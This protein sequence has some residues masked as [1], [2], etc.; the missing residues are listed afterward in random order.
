MDKKSKKWLYIAILL[1]SCSVF[2]SQIVLSNI[3]GFIFEKDYRFLSAS[4]ALLGLGA[5]GIF[6]SVFFKKIKANFPKSLSLTGFSYMATIVLPYLFLREI[7]LYGHNTVYIIILTCLAGFLNFFF[8]GLIISLIFAGTNNSIFKLSFFDLIG[9]TIGS[10]SIFFLADSLGIFSA[11][12]FLFAIGVGVFL[13][14]WIANYSFRFNKKTIVILA[15]LVAIILII[16]KVSFNTKCPSQFPRFIK[17]QSNSLT[18][19]CLYELERT[20]DYYEFGIS[21]REPLLTTN[22]LTNNLEN[23]KE[24]LDGFR[25]VIFKIANYKKVLVVG[26]GAGIDVSRALL[27]GSEEITAVEINKLMID[28]TNSFPQNLGQSPYQDKRVKTIVSDARVYMLQNKEKYDLLLLANARGFGRPGIQFLI[29]ENL[30][31]L[32]ALSEY[33]DKL[34][35][36]GTLAITNWSWLTER[37]LK[38]LAFLAV[39]KGLNPEKDL[40]TLSSFSNTE[41]TELMET[42]I[43]KKDGISIA[44]KGKI[45]SLADQFQ[46]TYQDNPVKKLQLADIKITTDDKPFPP[47]PYSTATNVRSN[48]KYVVFVNSTI[49][50]FKSFVI[51]LWSS[52]AILSIAIIAFLLKS[53]NKIKNIGIPMFFVGISFGLAGLEFALINKVTLLLGNPTYSHV[54]ALS[55][56]LLFGGLGSLFA[57]N[58]I[59]QKNIRKLILALSLVILTGYFSIDNIIKILLPLDYLLKILSIIGFI[60]IPSFLSGIFFPIALKKIR[61]RKNA[62]IPWLWGIDSL[63]F[64][65]ASLIIALIAIFYGIKIILIVSILGYL[66]ALVTIGNFEEL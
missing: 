15:L 24:R 13:S 61:E 52:V 51:I 50:S 39:Q 64:V 56:M 14:C 22:Y 65:T 11:I 8:G 46:F 16:T 1:T 21:V 23:I 63:A 4:L 25:N 66:L 60:F 18:R 38:A 47:T 3:V 42:I 19:L 33:I 5:G 43:F 35:P 37:Y 29:P 36:D 45:K 12:Y 20:E 59:I 28:L 34:E 17:T 48:N 49:G 58:K 10:I 32:E 41:D 55:S 44:E 9:A 62:L 57:T 53:K 40:V 26:S 7:P 30:Y 6:A 31:T 54:V 27:A 2:V